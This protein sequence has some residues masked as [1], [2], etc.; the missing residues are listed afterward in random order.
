MKVLLIFPLFYSSNG[1]NR[2]QSYLHESKSSYEIEVAIFCSN[3]VIE[4][5]SEKLARQ[6]GFSFFQRSNF[7]GGEG[8]FFELFQS[9]LMKENYQVIV[10]L[11]ESCEPM[12]SRWI[13]SIVRPLE[14]GYN[15]YGWHWNWRARKRDKSVRVDFGSTFRPAVVYKNPERNHPLNQ[16]ILDNVYDVPFFRHE[17]I[18]I[19]VDQ[20]PKNSLRI[21]QN[22]WGGDV[23]S[24]YFGLS[25]ERFFWGNSNPSVIKSPNF[26][27]P[28]ILKQNR[29]PLFTSYNFFRFRELSHKEKI[30][31]RYKPNHLVIRRLKLHYNMRILVFWGTNLVKFIVVQMLRIDRVS[32]YYKEM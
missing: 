5:E 21:N 30:S 28:M 6:F 10:Y 13:E 14:V 3:P 2:L 27:F 9:D 4:R 19:K 11:E 22:N 20:L 16:I 32:K 29:L 23:P 24:K 26:Q 17:C 25:M 31:T 18:S 7:G 15:I 1:L 8:A 12:S